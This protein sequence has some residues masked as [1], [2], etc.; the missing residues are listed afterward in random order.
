MLKF[1]RHSNERGETGPR[2]SS[3]PETV[4]NKRPKLDKAKRPEVPSRFN[5]EV[6]DEIQRL[7]S[8]QA[9]FESFLSMVSSDLTEKME[10]QKIV[11]ET[12]GGF[13]KVQMFMLAKYSNRIERFRQVSRNNLNHIVMLGQNK[14]NLD[15][16]VVI[17]C[18]NKHIETIGKMKR[19]SK[20]ILDVSDKYAVENILDNINLVTQL[21]ES[22]QPSQEK[23]SAK[24]NKWKSAGVLT[25]HRGSVVPA[26]EETERDISPLAFSR[27]SVPFD[28]LRSRESSGR[29]SK[30]S[31]I[32]SLKDHLAVLTKT[33]TGRR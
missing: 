21:S 8:S 27:M 32:M 9:A 6:D 12:D 30:L 13:A 33:Y 22:L 14:E 24:M 19:R 17:D 28:S 31:T 2:V 25:S 10:R 29:H 11:R 1:S 26:V 18:V 16:K 23:A 5:K 4:A 3:S 7:R 20:Q 15:S